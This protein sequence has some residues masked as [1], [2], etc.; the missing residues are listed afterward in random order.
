MFEV[1]EHQQQLALPEAVRDRRRVV[2][3][4]GRPGIDRIGDGGQDGL[5]VENRRELDEAGAV[6]EPG[7]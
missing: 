5:R 2:A 4:D 6:G 1:V 3:V 7:T